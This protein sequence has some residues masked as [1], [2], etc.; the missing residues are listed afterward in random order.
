MDLTIRFHQLNG[1][2]CDVD[3]AVPKNTQDVDLYIEEYLSEYF[4]YHSWEIIK[5]S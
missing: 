3:L 4:S 1:E 5:A 2:S